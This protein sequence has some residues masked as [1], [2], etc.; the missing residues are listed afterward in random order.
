[1]KNIV[2]TQALDNL[3]DPS[4]KDWTH[5]FSRKELIE[6]FLSK[7]SKKSEDSNVPSINVGMVG[8][9]N[10]GKSSLINVLFGVKRVAVASTPGK[11]KHLQTLILE[12]DILLCDCPG[13]VFPSV[14]ISKEEMVVDGILPIDELKEWRSPVKLVVERIPKRVLELT[15][16]LKFG[17]KKLTPNL[18]LDSYARSK[19]IM[20]HKNV[21]NASTASRHILKDYV[22]GKLLYCHPP[23]LS[24]KELKE[25]DEM[26]QEIID[27]DDEEIEEDD[28][29]EYY[30]DND[31]EGVQNF[32]E[33]NINQEFLKEKEKKRKL[34]KEPIDF[35]KIELE[36]L[37]LNKNEEEEE[38]EK[39]KT[40]VKQKGKKTKPPK[41]KKYRLQNY[42]KQS[43]YAPIP[44]K[45]L[46]KLL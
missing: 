2:S 4:E 22:S 46:K 26:N 44:I 14:T 27:D 1:M 23:P 40:D 19:G 38:E 37:N 42:E 25:I 30:T 13:L 31:E 16:G 32:N 35:F 39:V 33:T 29:D 6:F 43:S 12:K 24:E 7:I 11:T 41:D 34:D 9:P 5:I 18:L 8:Y 21:P 36:K 15:Y 3:V 10:V 45:E 17:D 20:S 28:D